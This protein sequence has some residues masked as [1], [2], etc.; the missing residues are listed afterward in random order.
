MKTKLGG[1]LRE[2][3]STTCPG[4]GGK[5]Y[6]STF[7]ASERYGAGQ[8]GQRWWRLR[9]EDCPRHYEIGDADSLHLVCAN[10]IEQCT[11]KR[12]E[13]ET[14]I[15]CCD[16]PRMRDVMLVCYNCGKSQLVTPE[17][18]Q[19]RAAR[20]A[21]EK[22]RDLCCAVPILV[23]HRILSKDNTRERIATACENCGDVRWTEWRTL[24]EVSDEA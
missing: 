3:L 11:G 22:P 18:M 14:P 2:V 24:C 1:L 12:P 10:W 21:G 23:E 19:F 17:G 13:V 6:L 16:N 7:I 15:S 8:Q 20:V 9:C 4:C 5:P